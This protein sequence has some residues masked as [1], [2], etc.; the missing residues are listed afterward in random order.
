MI[1]KTKLNRII[2]SV[3]LITIA[4]II[5][6]FSMALAY[7]DSEVRFVSKPQSASVKINGRVFTTPYTLKHPVTP[8]PWSH[9]VVISFPG[10]TRIKRFLKIGCAG[11]SRKRT[12]PG[13]QIDFSPDNGP[14]HKRSRHHFESTLELDIRDYNNLSPLV[15][16]SVLVND[17]PVPQKTKNDGKI[18]LYFGDVFY[19]SKNN[20]GNIIGNR[21]VEIEVSIELRTRGYNQIVKKYRLKDCKSGNNFNFKD[22]VYM[23][24][25]HKN[26]KVTK[27]ISEY[28]SLEMA[29]KKVSNKKQLKQVERSELKLIVEV[30]GRHTGKSLSGVKVRISDAW[31]F[32]NYVH[33]NKK[34]TD[35]NGR[36]T[37]GPKDLDGYTAKRGQQWDPRPKI[38]PKFEGGACLKIKIKVED[39]TRMIEIREGGPHTVTIEI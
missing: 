38:G 12:N 19:A 14:F 33:K 35:S 1:P 5:V 22:T 37:F 24:S 11:N 8:K 26:A 36:A 9:E 34:Y 31:G 32:F 15:N 17:V 18:M 4:I 2:H 10:K 16:V 25:I 7:A 39:K 27:H 3:L 20:F 23:R 28:K 29:G 6:T 21:D 13:V 30:R